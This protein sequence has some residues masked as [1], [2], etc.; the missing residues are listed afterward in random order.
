MSSQSEWV[1]AVGCGPILLSL[2]KVWYESDLSRL[3]VFVTNTQLTDMEGLTE[4]LQHAQPNDAG[5]TLDIFATA[6]GEVVNWEAVV[7]PF[8]FILYVSEPSDLEELRSLQAACRAEVKPLLSGMSLRGMGI[9]GPLYRPN[10]DNC[11]E[12]AWRRLHS[13]VF[14]AEGDTQAFSATATA[15]LSN[16]IVHEWHNVISAEEEAHCLDQCYIL[17][18]LTL[19]GGWHPILPHPF[20]S[21]YEPVRVVTDVE[22][23]LNLGA[24]QEPAGTEE[25]FACF[26]KLTS[27]VTGIFHVWEEG[28]LNQLP[29]AQC[30]VQPA[31]PLSEGPA[32]LLPAIV[33]SSLTH[34]EARRESGLAGLE[35]YMTRMTP[36]LVDGIPSYQQER[37]KMYIG[38]GCTF[39]EAVGRGLTARLTDELGKRTL[40]HELVVTRAEYTRIEDVHCRYFLQALSTLEGEPLLAVGEPLFGF[41]VVWVYSGGSWYGSV[42]LG[43]TSA[44]RESLQKALRKIGQFQVSTVIW[45]DHKL[46]SDIIPSANPIGHTSS[47]L[48]A[49]ESL[50]QQHK[51]LEVIDMRCESFL[52]EGP[53]S[54][55]GVQLREEEAL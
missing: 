7:Q 36:M 43:I 9:V 22:L 19:E 4:L 32:Q 44:L 25:W 6:G 21:G 42:G 20:V 28:G 16:L 35:S 30:L 45:N 55:L 50:K 48:S 10:E 18:P 54:V 13:S 5:A 23:N 52:N 51:R 12:S 2:V 26:S 11:W 3:K 39:A 17:D 33:S 38:A 34:E 1:L 40:E 29:L 14:P 37:E 24:D 27:T 31:D 41:P 15:M 49:I 53:F 8:S 46:Q 47:I